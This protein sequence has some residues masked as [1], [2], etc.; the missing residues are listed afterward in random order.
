MG[1]RRSALAALGSA[2]AVLAL[3]TGGAT[4]AGGASTGGDQG[5]EPAAEAIEG[6]VIVQW[7]PGADHAARVAARRGAGVT[8]AAEL[9]DPD[10]QLVETASGEGTA[11]AVEALESD[12]AVA[13]AEPDTLREVEA[14]P[15]DPHF[16][17]EWALQNTGQSV[18]GL[19]AGKPGNDIDVLPAWERTTGSPSV[20]VA[21][22][23]SGYRAD[24]PDLGPVEWTNPGEAGG[25]TGVDDDHDGKV[26]DVHGWDFVGSSTAA[27]T[28]DADPTDDDVI[29]GGHGVHTAGIIGGAANNGVGIAGVAPGARIMPLRVCTN[30][31]SINELRCPSSAIIAAI[32]FAGEKGVRV[33]NLSLG[34]TFRNQIEVNALAAHPGTLYVIAA[35]NDGANNDSG[36]AEPQGHHYPCD[37]KPATESSPVVA[38]AIENTICVAALDPSEALASY[39]DYGPTSVD[40][41]AP[42]TAVISTLPAE[43]TLFS[44]NFQ[45]NDFASKW[46]PFGAGFGSAGVGD[47]PLES[48]GMTDTPGAPALANHTYGVKT[49]AAI[50]VPTGEGSCRVEGRRYRRGGVVSAPGETNRGAPYGVI[51]GGSEYL[52]YFGGETSGSAMVPFRTVP[53]PGL[54]GKS[55]QP[56]FEYRA[57]SSPSAADGLWLDDVVLRCNASL[58]VPPTYAFEDGTSMA[59]P[60]VSGAAALLFSLEP[61]ASVTQVRTAI[62]SS[63]KP[64]ASLAGKTVTGGR[65]DVA[66]AMNAL[67]ATGSSGGGTVVTA[68]LPPGTIGAAEEA[69]RA[70]NPAATIRP[71]AATCKVPK[72]AGKTLA[73]AKAALGAAKCKLGK[74]SSPKR[75]GGAL[76][77]KSSSPGAGSK[78]SGAVAVTLAPKRKAGHRHH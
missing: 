41:G 66:A 62:L 55:V 28:E 13:V 30:D 78:T 44:D 77:V 34:G 17:E 10:F 63:A 68:P 56:F 2:V 60:M 43:Q 67:T 22:I 31:P 42:G 69:V 76:V 70:A 7:R 24:S 15:N 39:S 9:G 51:V 8:Y 29:S 32:N 33:A 40:I 27:P 71:A 73:Q 20:V 21:D 50:A 35:A 64:T 12:P 19:P 4:A 11:E 72:L 53:I 37:Y 16:G 59:T 74:V 23:D 3:A 61:G 14:I 5:P 36:L 26:D 48:L 54:G 1:M 6:A 18:N 58:S 46:T 45:G 47:G 49:T 25:T 65:L 75:R 57:S 38:G 52:E